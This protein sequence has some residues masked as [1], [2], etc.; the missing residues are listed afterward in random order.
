MRATKCSKN[1]AVLW[2]GQQRIYLGKSNAENQLDI[3]EIAWN[4]KHLEIQSPEAGQLLTTALQS[5]SRQHALH[6]Y[7][8]RLC[9][10]DVFC[11]TRVVTGD[12]EAVE[13]EL[14]A[15]RSR[16]QLYLSLGLGEK[17]TGN[18]TEKQDGQPDYALTSIVG[19]RTIQCICNSVAS[20]RVT[21]ES[22][23]PATLA[24]TRAMGLL[25]LD[26]DEPVMFLSKDS[27]RC[28]LAICRSGRLMLSYRM[29]GVSE[30]ADIAQ[31]IVSHLTRLRRFCQR[32]RSQDGQTLQAVYVF[33]EDR[34]VAE[35]S[36]A[37][38]QSTS[39]LQLS[40]IDFPETLCVHNPSQVATPVV[41]A[42]WAA[43]MWSDERKD[44]LPAPDWIDQLRKLKR[45]SVREV[46]FKNFY[47]TAVAAGLI[48]AV[49][50]LKWYDHRKLE[51]KL[52][53]LA[54]VNEERTRAEAEFFEWESKHLLI[55]SYRKL[56]SELIQADWAKIVTELAPCLP[57][58]ARLESFSLA[59]DNG[60]NL[61]GMMFSSDTTYEMLSAIKRLPTMQEVSLESVSAVG[62]VSRSQLQFEVKCRLAERHMVSAVKLVG[63]KDSIE[64]KAVD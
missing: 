1:R 63:T 15:I 2:I 50:A 40:T 61:R 36:E 4:P 7:L 51:C 38:R 52:S 22:I 54:L 16:S 43:L 26:K 32:V 12:K 11:V 59:E 20:A 5:L 34:S 58:N 17:L 48:L 30:P 18:L 49:F 39:K 25:G 37:L 62:D 53:E 29:S 60:V 3:Q 33:G 35:L 24:L 9:L 28:D 47:L 41:L 56:E 6:R 31:Q 10:D 44:C 21:L 8:V 13:K 45:T 42:L 27:H 46:L 19:L 23:E 57:P 14:D 55:D 64:P